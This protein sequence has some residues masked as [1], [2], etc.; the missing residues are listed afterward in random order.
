MMSFRILWTAIFFAFA[1]MTPSAGVAAA[2]E[3]A[4]SIEVQFEFR[5]GGIYVGVVTDRLQIFD[6][7]RYRI[8]SIAEPEGAAK[9]L[10]R[11]IVRISEGRIDSNLGL[12]SEKYFYQRGKNPPRTAEFDWKKNQLHLQEEG[13]ESQ[14]ISLDEAGYDRLSFLYHFYFS[15][16]ADAD[17]AVAA[18]IRISNYRRQAGEAIPLSLGGIGNGGN[19]DGGNSVGAISARIGRQAGRIMAGAQSRIFAA[20]P[21]NGRSRRNAGFFGDCYPRKLIRRRIF[22]R[23]FVTDGKKRSNA[24]KTR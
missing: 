19:G 22:A 13:G 21:D 9:L 16:M 12:R 24:V 2:D 17:F 7:G 23:L 4:D 5:Y 18:E 6:D 10:A 14:K 15:Q 8:E 3:S 11:G 1:G 20:A